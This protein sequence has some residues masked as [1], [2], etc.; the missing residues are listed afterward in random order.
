MYYYG[1]PLDVYLRA[2]STCKSLA[3][4][5]DGVWSMDGKEVQKLSGCADAELLAYIGK[6]NTPPHLLKTADL[7]VKMTSRTCEMR[8]MLD[9]DPSYG[10]KNLLWLRAM[11]AQ[12]IC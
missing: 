11:L 7:I 2:V 9:R 8:G 12:S 1:K 4:Y 5:L 3:T 6:N 10:E